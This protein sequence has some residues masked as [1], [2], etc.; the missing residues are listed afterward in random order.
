MA[1]RGRG[2]NRFLSDGCCFCEE[3][4]LFFSQPA[5]KKE[6]EEEEEVVV[7]ASSSVAQA[8]DEKQQTTNLYYTKSVKYGNQ[9]QNKGS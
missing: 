9:K 7:R 1:S 3:L 4:E 6:E 5:I 8:A 2:V